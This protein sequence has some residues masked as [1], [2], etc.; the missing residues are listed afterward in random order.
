[1]LTVPQVPVPQTCFGV[2]N[3]SGLP[4]D[5]ENITD[6]PFDSS[7]MTSMQLYLTEFVIKQGM[8]IKPGWQTNCDE[9]NSCKSMI[10]PVIGRTDDMPNGYRK[11]L[12]YW[13]YLPFTTA[14][15]WT[16]SVKLRFM[17]IKPPRVGGKLL[18]R[19]EPDSTA[20]PALLQANNQYDTLRRGIV[21]EWDLAQSS[22]FELDLPGFN[23]I[24][25]RPTWV[26]H[27]S[28]RDYRG[29]PLTSKMYFWNLTPSSVHLGY[30]KVEMAND[31][32]PGSIFPDSFR[33]LVFQSFENAQF[34]QQCDARSNWRHVLNLGQ[35]LFLDSFGTSN[36][37]P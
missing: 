15:F 11:N 13:H 28:A 9:V 32:Q 5:P 30:L 19:Y 34:Y 29:S 31:I 18:F 8:E 4:S 36:D 25:H 3:D 23:V 16:G 2:L 33:I 6:I 10:L 17:A 37:T 26:P 27:F 7:W 22:D 14:R 12:R 21:R 20:D 24:S 1:M 35:P